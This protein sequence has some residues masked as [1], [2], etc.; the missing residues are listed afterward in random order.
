MCWQ[1]TS[2]IRS[3]RLSRGRRTANENRMR[4]ESW[5]VLFGVEI[6]Q[7]SVWRCGAKSVD[8]FSSDR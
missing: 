7:H 4:N 8:R 5:I 6:W 1:R 3:M 2:V